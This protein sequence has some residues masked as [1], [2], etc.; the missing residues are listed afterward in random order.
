MLNY[1]LLPME[2][3]FAFQITE[4]SESIKRAINYVGGSFYSSNG[5]T[6]KL[7]ACPE[8][9][10]TSRTIYLRGNDASHNLRV[11][12]TWNLNSNL[13]RDEILSQVNK[14]LSEI[15]SFAESYPYSYKIG[16]NTYLG[17]YKVNQNPV[18]S[19]APEAEVIP[20][21]FSFES[22]WG[23]NRLKHSRPIVQVS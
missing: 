22:G 6:I 13:E 21:D 18:M 23:A 15:I 17:A 7:D 9:R 20:V 5:W 3:A 8:I 12:R 2:R 11:D 4:Q 19:S 16:P 14:A 1:S 10:V